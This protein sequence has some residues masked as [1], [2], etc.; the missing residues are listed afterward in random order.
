MKFVEEIAVE[1]FLPTVRAMLAADLRER[2][3]TQH[4]VAEAIGV[5]QSAVSK[6]AHGDVATNE[7]IEGDERVRDLVS[8]VGEGLATGEM[9][10]LQALVEIEVLIRRL[11]DGD[12]LATLH[13]ESMPELVGYEGGFDIH[14][15]DSVLRTTERVLASV[16]RGLRTLT[17]TSGFAT[18]I[19]AVG[20]NLV[21]CL[22]DATDV[23]DVA[24]VPGR[25][26]D[27][28]GQ[29]TV[30]ADPEFGVSEH[31]A[32]VLLAARSA[33]VDARAAA[34]IR[35]D[36]DLLESLRDA[37][38]DTVQFDPA[39]EDDAA[40]IVDALDGRDPTATFALSQSGD[41]GIE[42]ISYVIGPDAPT[43]ARVVR[44]LLR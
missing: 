37:G 8:R 43:V 10:R 16:R 31:V 24:G 22:P 30:P 44:D 2:G 26:V 11:E 33:G 38:H 15:P 4:E 27:V 12:L 1:E 14:D 36:E 25:I 13:E 17:N 34:C 35:Y 9:S 18:L 7:R 23:D 21:E 5:S 3:L 29:A 20:S 41:Y 19:P 42:P 28:K 39:G 6:Y 40:A 32:S